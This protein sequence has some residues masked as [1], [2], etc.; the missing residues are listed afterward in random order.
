MQRIDAHTREGWLYYTGQWQAY[1]KEKGRKST[2]ICEFRPLSDVLGRRWMVE[3]ATLESA[4]KHAI[5]KRFFRAA[6]AVTPI[7]TPHGMR[8]D[9]VACG[10]PTFFQ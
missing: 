1:A 2:K 3:V 7:V 5:S 8:F 10:T 6:R 9:S 4:R